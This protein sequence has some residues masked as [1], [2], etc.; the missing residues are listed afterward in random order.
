MEV[1]RGY[2]DSV[3]TLLFNNKERLLELYNAIE[4][5][6]YTDAA[7]IKINTLRDIIFLDKVNDVSFEFRK[8]QIVLIE[9]QST[10]NPNMALR[11]LMYIGRL[12]EKI[13]DSK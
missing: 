11:L 8:K 9:H 7:D 1:N 12:Y 4:G 5:T 2:K 3:F 13:M 6:N 10:I